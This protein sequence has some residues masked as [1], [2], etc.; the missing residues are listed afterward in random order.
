MKQNFHKEFKH[1]ASSISFD[2]EH[3][4]T[5]Q[6]NISRYDAAADRGKLNYSSLETAKQK[7]A[8]IKRE[9]INNLETYLLEFEKNALSNGIDVLWA[10]DADSA[11]NYVSTILK[12]EK[13]EMLVK[14]KS[15]VT[16]EIDLNKHLEKNGIES[17]ETDLGEFIVQEAGEKPY[18]IVTPAMHKSKEDVADLFNKKFDTPKNSSPE[19]LTNFVR[20]RLRKKFTS[21]G[22]GITGGNFL[23]AETGSVVVT[24][25]EGNAQMST[26]FPRIHIAIVGIEK[27]IPRFNDL[28]TM[29]PLLAVHGTGQQITSYNT[30]FSGAKRKN[31]IDGPEKMYV[32]L[33]DNGRSKLLSHEK[34]KEAL[35]CIRCGA[36]LNSCPVYKNIGGY[37]Y[38]TTYSGPI[39]SVIT[40][41]M[42]GMKDFGHLSFSSSLCGKCTEVCPVKINLHKLLLY[43]RRD[44]VE[45]TKSKFIERIG[46]KLYSLITTNQRFFDMG[47]SA[48]R[49]FFLQR[50]GKKAWGKYRELPVFKKSFKKESKNNTKTK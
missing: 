50:F 41:L 22:A 28:G 13:V 34:Q 47:N 27:I 37:S 23:V 38:N 18:H 17:V 39:G 1:K 49:N 25:N 15:M 8:N 4:A 16:E 6:F 12:D 42:W 14:S 32:I 10:E 11:V 19:Y 20:E 31:E 2:R 40:P 36:C 5:I 29:L 45:N 43:N 9:V 33:L 7:A 21:A 44:A 30:I 35:C 46:F 3:R 26:S 24:E 48:V